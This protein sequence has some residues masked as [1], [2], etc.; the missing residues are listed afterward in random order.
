MQP[1]KNNT[2]IDVPLS[3]AEFDRFQH[4]T[5]E[6]T[7]IFFGPRRRNE[8]QRHIHAI[9]KKQIAPDMNTLYQKLAQQKTNSPIW[10]CYIDT[11]IVG[12]TYFFREKLLFQALQQKI[13][14]DIIARHQKDKVLRIWS[15][16]CSTG[17]EPYSLSILLDQLLGSEIN[18]WR[19]FILATDINKPSLKKGIDGLYRKWS[20]R[21]TPENI[22]L[23]YFQKENELYRIRK[24]IQ[25]RVM[26]SYLNLKDPVYPALSTCTHAMDLILWR[27]VAI[28]LSDTVIADVLKRFYQCL[29]PLG[30]FNIGASEAGYM[31]ET[32]FVSKQYSG[33]FI[34]QK[35]P[36]P[37]QSSPLPVYPVKNT[38]RP[39]K[40]LEFNKTFRFQTDPPKP[41][42]KL[43]QQS[44]L[45]M[46]QQSANIRNYSQA[47]AQY[48]SY[49]NKNSND[50]DV[51]YQLA[52]VYAN[53]G[54]LAHAKEACLSAIDHNPLL[55]EAYYISGLINEENGEID[56]AIQDYKKTLYLQ[57]DFVLAH[58]HLAMVY[59]QIKDDQQAERHRIHAIRILSRRSGDETLLDADDLTVAQLLAMISQE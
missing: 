53:S 35:L 34:Y 4:L 10:D 3:D 20:L 23:T 1:I 16:G 58:Y 51:W 7:G 9:L 46:A 5:H 38:T 49:L 24:D 55:V 25:K 32:Q 42:P 22:V 8:L 28:Y 43:A 48:R 26:F 12:E 54:D 18:L 45:E 31:G 17:E 30:Y 40:G 44:I 57:S 21:Q 50:A 13:L 41:K 56:E 14:P 33:T 59:L 36:I 27:N 11:I 52:R 6:R 15:A 37:Q 29:L 2:V 39:K 47:I 19:I